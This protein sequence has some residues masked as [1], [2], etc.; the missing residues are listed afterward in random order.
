[1]RDN[2]SEYELSWTENELLLLDVP[3]SFKIFSWPFPISLS[4]FCCSEDSFFGS[5]GKNFRPELLPPGFPL[6][7][8]ALGKDSTTSIGNDENS[9]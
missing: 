8:Y 2:S 7:A 4:T 6:L 3:I 5:F 1:M 9:S